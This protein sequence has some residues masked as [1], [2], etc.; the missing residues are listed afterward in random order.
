MK[1]IVKRFS[2]AEEYQQICWMAKFALSMPVTNAWSECGGSAIKGIKTHNRSSIKNDL[3]SALLM[4][5]IN[6]VACNTTAA[7]TLITQACVEFQDKKR[8]EKPCSFQSVIKSK[9]MGM[10]VSINKEVPDLLL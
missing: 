2:G 8:Q 10:Q 5:S 3:L 7:N 4:I 9:S 1:Q 6:F